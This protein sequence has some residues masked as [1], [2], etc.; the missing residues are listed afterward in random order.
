M[1]A[2]PRPTTRQRDPPSPPTRICAG[3]RRATVSGANTRCY[4]GLLAA[5]LWSS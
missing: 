4:H 2:A 5:S 1:Q 3:S